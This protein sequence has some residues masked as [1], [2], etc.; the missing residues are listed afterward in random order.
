MKE[1]DQS[2]HATFSSSSAW[3]LMTNN[4]KGEAFGAPGLKYIKQVNLEIKLGR[5]LTCEREARST[6]WGDFCEIYVFNILD[7][8]YRNVTDF[9]YFHPDVKAWSGK[10]DVIKAETVGDVKAPF[11]LEVFCDKIGALESGIHK[12]REEFP[13]DYY[14]HVSNAILLNANDLKVT[15]FEAIIYTPFRSE[16]DDIRATAMK[17]EERFKWIA[18]AN[19][20]EL[21]WVPDG[22]YYKNLNTYRFEIPQE[23]KIA[24]H[25]RVVEAGKMLITP[26]LIPA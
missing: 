17:S 6:S 2:R 18:F 13:D 1:T 8:S 22:G 9:R 10:P 7:L 21:P 15:H 16:L 24:L 19:D 20:D 5:A 14:Q 4:K 11:N 12:Y 25:N 26:K 23:D 3:K